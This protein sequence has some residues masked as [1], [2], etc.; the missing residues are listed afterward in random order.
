[1]SPVL[2]VAMLMLQASILPL[3]CSALLLLTRPCYSL[4]FLATLLF[5][6]LSLCFLATS[7]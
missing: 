2:L 1:M 4:F 7:A 6:S 3:L 5:C